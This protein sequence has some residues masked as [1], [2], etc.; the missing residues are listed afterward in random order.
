MNPNQY[1]T[2]FIAEL[3]HLVDH[4]A[5]AISSRRPSLANSMC[6][7]ALAI[8]TGRRR[9]RWPTIRSMRHKM[10]PG[11]RGIFPPKFDCVRARTVSA[12]TAGDQIVLLLSAMIRGKATHQEPLGRVVGGPGMLRYQLESASNPALDVRS[13]ARG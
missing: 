9:S 8:G 12:L 3:E 4:L 10:C 7:L 1:L 11:R 6:A 13:I 5:R 2:K